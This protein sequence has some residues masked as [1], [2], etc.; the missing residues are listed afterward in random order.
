MSLIRP[1]AAAAL[2]RWREALLG[3]G[4]LCLGGYW[5]TRYGLYVW[6]GGALAVLGLALLITGLQRGRFAQGQGGPGV[7][8]LDEGELSYFGPLSGGHMP[9]AEITRIVFDPTGTPGHWCLESATAQPLYIPVTA[10]GAE[11]LFDVFSSLPGLHTEEMLVTIATP[12][13][14]PTLIWRRP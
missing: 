1:E 14:A 12:P 9:I 8:Q 6:A 7:V 13:K 5:L 2:R 11:L 4:L 3:A 10:A